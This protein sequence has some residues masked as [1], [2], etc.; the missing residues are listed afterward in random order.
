MA[1]KREVIGH[2]KV[3]F[4]WLHKLAAGVS[5]IAFLVVIAA[6]VMAEVSVFT[7]AF[8][9][10]VVILAVSVVSRILVRV[11]ATY[12]EMNSGKA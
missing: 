7:I 6:G 8:R 9:A 1:G 5:L 2:K 10:L 4:L 3:S 11:L 12:E